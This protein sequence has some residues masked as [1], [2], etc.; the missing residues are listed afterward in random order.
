MKTL[1]WLVGLTVIG[2]GIWKYAGYRDVVK[3]GIDDTHPIGQLSLIESVLV[4]EMRFT[5]D[6]GGSDAI[7][8]EDLPA[9]SITFRYL[10]TASGVPADKIWI[11]MGPEG[12]II[13]ISAWTRPYSTRVYGFMEEHWTRVFGEAPDYAEGQAGSENAKAR[14]KW[15]SNSSNG[16]FICIAAK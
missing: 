4:N 2:F 15:A 3:Y 7:P 16:A 10:D 6:E 12:R 14:A 5:K 9:P 8:W 13:S 1:A 11:Q